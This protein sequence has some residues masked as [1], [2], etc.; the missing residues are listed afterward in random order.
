M[1]DL[2]RMIALREHARANDLRHRA[3]TDDLPAS[4]FED[5]EPRNNLCSL[6]KDCILTIEDRGTICKQCR[7]MGSMM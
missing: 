2:D 1:T 4:V 6:C 5:I 3:G 7:L